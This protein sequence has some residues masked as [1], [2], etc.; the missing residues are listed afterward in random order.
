MLRTKKYYDL[1]FTNL[2]RTYVVTDVSKIN[3][4]LV[5]TYPEIKYRVLIAC[6]RH[7]L[8]LLWKL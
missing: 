4:T 1:S 3:Y 8:I 2:F 7:T 5:G 6:D